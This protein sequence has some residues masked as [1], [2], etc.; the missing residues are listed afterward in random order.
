MKLF[1]KEILKKLPALYTQEA[2]ENPEK[3]MVFYVKLF[4][5]DSN[6]TWFIAEYDPEKEIAWG[7]VMGLENEYGTIDIKEL[8]EVRG[9]FGLPIE[10]DISFDPIKEKE[11][12]DEIKRGVA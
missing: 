7:Y 11:L 9:P 12:M 1:T 2:H 10:R 5:P 6:W 3:E 8:K 4:T